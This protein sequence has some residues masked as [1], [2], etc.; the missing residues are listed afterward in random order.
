M[1]QEHFPLEQR[2]RLLFKQWLEGEKMPGTPY[3]EE[4]PKGLMTWP[5]L[6]KLAIPTTAILTIVSWWNDV[7]LEFGVILTVSFFIS[8]L[9]R[10]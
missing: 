2:L 1:R 8:F 3:L 6:L 5:K 4:P 10:R 9:V 7:L